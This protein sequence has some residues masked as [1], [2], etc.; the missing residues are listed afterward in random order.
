MLATSASLKDKERE[1][2]ARIKAHEAHMLGVKMQISQAEEKKA[3]TELMNR[4]MGERGSNFP[5]DTR[6]V[7][8][9]SSSASP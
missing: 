7:T 5:A 1:E 3:Q 2:A 6:H 9:E 4:M 8:Q